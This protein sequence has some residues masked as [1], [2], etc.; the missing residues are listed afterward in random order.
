MLHSRQFETKRRITWAFSR[1]CLLYENGC[2]GSRLFPVIQDCDVRRKV[3]KPHIGWMHGVLDT[4]PQELQHVH[5]DFYG[6]RALVKSNGFTEVGTLVDRLSGYTRL[7]PMKTKAAT[8][9]KRVLEKWI[10]ELG[11]LL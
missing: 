8:E 11:L 10:R 2:F 1:H 6:F 5:L 3:K 4:P 9:I 7:Y